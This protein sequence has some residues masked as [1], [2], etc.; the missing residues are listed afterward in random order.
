MYKKLFQNKKA[1]FFDLDGTLI[2]N[3]HLWK[4]AYKRVFERNCDYIPE[5]FDL[6]YEIGRSSLHQWKVLNDFFDFSKS[7]K[8]IQ[9]LSNETFEEYIKI[10]NETQ[11]LDVREGFYEF[12]FDIRQHEMDLALVTGLDRRIAEMVL[13]KIE[14]DEVFDLIICGDDVRK[15]K[16]DPEIYLTAAKVLKQTPQKIL[17]FE[18]SLTGVSSAVR[19]GMD[20]VVVWDR[21]TPKYKFSEK[22]VE[23]I[24]DFKGFAGNMDIGGEDILKELYE[25]KLRQNGVEIPNPNP[26][27]GKQPDQIS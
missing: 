20:V 1:I 25:E 27:I 21:V 5:K 15:P 17:V 11:D 23:F 4:E 19:A 14:I 9:D 3:A 18:D 16:P 24:I 26:E 12:M 13:K 7:K 22:V 8:T 6:Y 10:V 2:D